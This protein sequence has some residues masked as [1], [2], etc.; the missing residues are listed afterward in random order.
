MYNSEK[1]N[2]NKS[3]MIQQVYIQKYLKTIEN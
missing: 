1:Q 3:N 2:E